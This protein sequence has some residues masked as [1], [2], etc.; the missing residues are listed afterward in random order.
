MAPWTRSLAKANTE[1]EPAHLSTVEK[2]H[3]NGYSPSPDRAEEGGRT[4]RKLNRI[5]KPRTHSISGSVADSDNSDED[6]IKK[7]MIEEEGNAIKYRTC[8][9]K[10]VCSS[11]DELLCLYDFDQSRLFLQHYTPF[12]CS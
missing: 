5:D 4:R 9:W 2:G 7:Q 8:S 1:N 11:N 10:K 3:E 12:N 6:L